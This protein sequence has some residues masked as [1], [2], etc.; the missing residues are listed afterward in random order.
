MSSKSDWTD[1]T[2]CVCLGIAVVCVYT[3]IHTLMHRIQCVCL[4]VYHLLV[5][6]S[7]MTRTDSW[8]EQREKHGAKEGDWKGT[9]RSK[10]I[11]HKFAK[12]T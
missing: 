9:E 7:R 10:S 2:V 5:A 3:S 1:T 4:S 8:G 12:E 6:I 11:Q